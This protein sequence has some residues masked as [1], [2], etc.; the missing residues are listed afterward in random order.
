M[1]N[2]FS[3]DFPCLFLRYE[4][5]N[6]NVFQLE[7]AL[8][9]DTL[10]EFEEV[11]KKIRTFKNTLSQSFIYSISQE[12]LQQDLLE[13]PIAHRITTCTE[14]ISFVFECLFE[15]YPS[16]AQQIKNNILIKA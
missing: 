9:E 7:I 14:G 4:L 10:E 16:L 2:N 12:D 13:Y 11:A 3:S 8:K 5:S 6:Q 15:K 1:S